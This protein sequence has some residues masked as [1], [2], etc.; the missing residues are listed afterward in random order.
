MHYLL[1]YDVSSDYL[2][3]RGE[4]RDA[5]LAKAW[6]S[7]GRGELLLAGAL[8]DPL[9][10]AVLLFEAESGSVAE[11]FARSD[12]YVVNGLVRSWRVRPWTT[13]AGSTATNP[14]HPAP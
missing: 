2:E 8:A 4:F 7:H 12:P 9:D 5:H 6:D 3:R 13:V 1:F 11:E 10:T 14:V